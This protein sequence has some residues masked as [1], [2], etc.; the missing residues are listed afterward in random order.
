MVLDDTPPAQNSEDLEQFWSILNFFFVKNRFLP[1]TRSAP[2]GT[3]KMG[4]SISQKVCIFGFVMM[5]YTCLATAKTFHQVLGPQKVKKHAKSDL[6]PLFG[7]TGSSL[8][9]MHFWRG[10]WAPNWEIPL[11]L[12]SRHLDL[13]NKPTWA[14]FGSLEV[15]QKWAERRATRRDLARYASGNFPVFHLQHRTTQLFDQFWLFMGFFTLFDVINE[16]SCWLDSYLPI[17]DDSFIK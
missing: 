15:P 10:K 3:L 14:S 1:S 17:L 5:K 12:E 2:R 13:S 6:L 9:R 4:R 8:G 7:H 16:I 11:G